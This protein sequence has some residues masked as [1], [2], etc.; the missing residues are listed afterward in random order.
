MAQS[1]ERLTFGFGSGHDQVCGVEPQD[2][3]YTDTVELTSDSLPL[4]K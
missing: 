4:S 1:V 2:G 3:L